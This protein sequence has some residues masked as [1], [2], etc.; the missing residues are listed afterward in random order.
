MLGVSVGTVNADVKPFSSER[1]DREIKHDDEPAPFSSEPADEP[2]L[3]PPE[4]P[5][6]E[7]RANKRITVR[8]ARAMAFLENVERELRRV[9]R[10]T[11]LA[12][13][14]RWAPAHPGPA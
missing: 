2:A 7:K 5:K 14:R 10:G 8:D 6:K 4:K 3:A 13:G 11:V 12:A 9:E 1:D